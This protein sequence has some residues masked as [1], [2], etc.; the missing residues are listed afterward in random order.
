MKPRSLIILAGFLLSLSASAQTTPP[1]DSGVKLLS[2]PVFNMSDAEVTA[3]IEGKVVMGLTVERTGEVKNVF[4][5]AGPMWPC[6]ARPVKAL[7]E[8]FARLNDH[9]HLSKFSPAIKNGSPV[10]STISFAVDLDKA[11]QLIGKVTPKSLEKVGSKPKQIAAGV[12]N[13]KAISLPKPEYPLAARSQRAKGVVSIAV[14]IDEKGDVILA[15]STRGDPM[16]QGAAREAACGAKFSPTK[17]LNE[18]VR[19]S[20][21]ITYTFMP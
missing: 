12:V 10:Q 1:P 4:P 19:V 9:I 5:S 3:G 16:L 11:P 13:G 14:L 20:G 15:G 2:A 18:P 21:I 6:G 8:L 17:V 7:E